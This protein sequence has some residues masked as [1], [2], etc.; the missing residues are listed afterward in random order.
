M[1]ANLLIHKYFSVVNSTVLHNPW[2]VESVDGDWGTEEPWI[3][4]LTINY[5]WIFDYMEG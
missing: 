1:G 4:G 2:L 5:T 3:Q